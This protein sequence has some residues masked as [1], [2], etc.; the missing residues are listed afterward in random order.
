M[1]KKR[2][3]INFAVDT[4]H[5]PDSLAEAYSEI[6]EN[7][8]KALH[9]TKFDSTSYIPRDDYAEL[10]DLA[11]YYLNKNSFDTYRFRHLGTQHRIRLMPSA[12]Y[13]LKMLLLQTHLDANAKSFKGFELLG[14]FVA[15]IYTNHWFKTPVGA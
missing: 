3:T 12:I 11:L 2:S 9:E 1:K 4:T 10:L 15:A 5:I 13:A 14:Y 7:A 6:L 8:F